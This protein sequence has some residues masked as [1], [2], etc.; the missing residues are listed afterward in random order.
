MKT[1]EYYMNLP[2][3]LVLVPDV[4]EG[5]YA[6]Y[7]PHLRGCLTCGDT[8]AEVCALAIDA[9]REWL[10]AALEDGA[11]IPEPGEAEDFS[12]EGRWQIRISDKDMRELAKRSHMPMALRYAHSADSR[13]QTAAKM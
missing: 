3:Q 1:L 11:V 12:F 13:G 5:G 8:M 4:D 7:F 2:Y 9:K 10:S 6:A